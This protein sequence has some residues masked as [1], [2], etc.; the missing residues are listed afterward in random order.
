MR[1]NAGEPNRTGGGAAR[2]SARDDIPVAAP[3]SMA[4]A[5]GATTFPGLCRGSYAVPEAAAS[6]FACPATSRTLRG[7]ASQMKPIESNEAATHIP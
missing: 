3:R 4:N 6:R 7:A 2:F 5:P 1:E